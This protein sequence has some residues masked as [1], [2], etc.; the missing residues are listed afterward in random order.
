MAITSNTHFIACSKCTTS[1]TIEPNMVHCPHL[2]KYNKHGFGHVFSH[3][4]TCEIS[5]PAWKNKQ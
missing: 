2:D 4:I 5:N 1:D 3:C